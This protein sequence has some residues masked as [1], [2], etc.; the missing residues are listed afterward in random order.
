MAKISNSEDMKAR[1]FF[2]LVSNM[3]QAQKDYFRTRDQAILRTCKVLEKQV[4]EEIDRVK[5]V[6]DMIE[7]YNEEKSQRLTSR[8]S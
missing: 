7:D 1:E 6:V 2:Y 5:R 8:N 4:D 3:R